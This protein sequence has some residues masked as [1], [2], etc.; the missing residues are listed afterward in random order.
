MIFAT[1]WYVATE[2][3]VYE[4]DFVVIDSSIRFAETVRVMLRFNIGSLANT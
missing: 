1:M 3:H 4:C 2:K